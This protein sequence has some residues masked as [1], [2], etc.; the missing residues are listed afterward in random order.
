MAEALLKK[1]LSSLGKA[2]IAVRSA[3]VRALD[4]SLPT[5]ETIEV[6]RSE[7]VDVSNF[8]AAGI[9]DASIRSSDLILVMTSAHKDEIIKRLSEAASK[10]FL[11]REYGRIDKDGEFIDTDIPDPIGLGISEY[12]ACLG[13]IKEAVER[14]A[15][16]L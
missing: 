4:G 6:L 14:T 12:R 7:G 13:M 11:L 9:T 1:R 8:R 10:T 16:L 3:G 2:G 5:H 15:K